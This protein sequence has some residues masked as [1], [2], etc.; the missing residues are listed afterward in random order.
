MLRI[1]ND[2]I[3]DLFFN[4][5]K[6][7]N[8]NFFIQNWIKENMGGAY[9]SCQDCQ[10]CTDK[11]H[12]KKLQARVK[13]L[14]EWNPAF[15]LKIILKEREAQSE[16][17]QVIPYFLNCIDDDLIK[18]CAQHAPKVAINLALTCGTS[19]SELLPNLLA[20]NEPHYVIQKRQAEQKVN[21]LELLL[22]RTFPS[23]RDYM[24]QMLFGP[25]GYYAKGAVDFKKDFLTFPSNPKTSKG[26]CA[27]FANQL[28]HL[29]QKL[30]ALGKIKKTDSFN[31]LE[32]GA[33][34]GDLCYGIL[35]VIRGMAEV[36]S[37]YKELNDTIQYCIVERSTALH[38]R[39]KNKNAEFKSKTNFLI[40]D[41]RDL[42][43]V[44]K[45]SD[46]T[47]YMAAV[48]SNEL[49]DVFPSHK[50]AVKNETMVAEVVLPL[51]SAELLDREFKDSLSAE[52]VAQLKEKSHNYNKILYSY[53]Q[54]TINSSKIL[55]S[56]EDFNKLHCIASADVSRTKTF[57]FTSVFIDV[58]CFPE[59]DH[60]I[61]Q[62]PQIR[63]K[64]MTEKWCL[65]LM[66]MDAYLKNVKNILID[67]GEVITVD[68]GN[69][70]ER[71]QRCQFRTFMYYGN[72]QTKFGSNIFDSERGKFIPGDFDI[73]LDVPFTTLVRE[74]ERLGLMPVF[75]GKQFQMLPETN[76]FSESVVPKTVTAAFVSESKRAEFH[77]CI[78]E[79]TRLSAHVNLPG[80]FLGCRFPVTDEELYRDAYHKLTRFYLDFERIKLISDYFS[81]DALDKIEDFQKILNLILGYILENYFEKSLDTG[82]V[83]SYLR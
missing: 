24:D 47:H 63:Y 2:K 7:H 32:C 49:I 5:L 15:V 68:Y 8:L 44:L 35:S 80:R 29:R 59:L 26:F 64:V 10:K 72:N 33:G 22:A 55:L 52:D 74:G 4:Q 38:E 14:I 3:F 21:P 34:D 6:Q 69:V 31:V 9:F 48:I 79:N 67:S 61:I 75:F 27:G 23:T 76:C 53:C 40:G 18:F 82:N 45:I 20:A 60:F 41:A 17:S 43:Q 62:N 25:A 78:Q 19:I 30:I 73:T 1:A 13:K 16:N 57:Q 58:R 66:G 77:A 83:Q 11:N 46:P 51:I 12:Q 54:C 28:L 36:R 39:Q 50:V 65:V 71:M 56:R 81:F 70:D 37:D 42:Q